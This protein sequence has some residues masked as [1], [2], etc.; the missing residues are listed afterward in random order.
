M[1]HLGR[2][3]LS[4]GKD[5]FVIKHKVKIPKPKAPQLL[6]DSQ[7]TELFVNLDSIKPMRNLPNAE[8]ILPVMLRLIYCCGLRISEAINLK[9]ADVDLDNQTI[10]ILKSKGHK[11][12]KLYIHSDVADLLKRY[13]IYFKS[14]NSEREYFFHSAKKNGSID[15]SHIRFAFNSALKNI[16]TLDYNQKKPT[17]HGLRH[18]FA[19]NSMR[20]CIE[21]EKEDFNCWI[22][23]L[24]KYM[25][26]STSGETSQYLHIVS[27]LFPS[28]KSKLDSLTEGFGV[29]YV[30]E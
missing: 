7:L 28:Y 1:R 27:D 4:I 23:Y 17:V 24:S 9:I 30:E 14:I 6:N 29:L 2:Y 18:L 19:V 20:K 15:P 3:Q 13:H 16:S 8:L 25:G 12:R 11:N 10:S 22:K 21:S 26:H 5:A